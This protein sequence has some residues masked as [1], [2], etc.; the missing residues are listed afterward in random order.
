M[1]YLKLVPDW[2]NELAEALQKH[3]EAPLAQPVEKH[4][5]VFAL[6]LLFGFILG[7]LMCLTDVH[8]AY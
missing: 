8:G 6:G 3:N 4:G 2:R 5:A 7:V 1:R